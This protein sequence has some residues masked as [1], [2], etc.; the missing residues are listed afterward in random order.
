[1]LS[2][3]VFG[4]VE[5]SSKDEN[6]DSEGSSSS[7]KDKVQKEGTETDEKNEHSTT[8]ARKEDKRTVL[9]QFRNPVF[10][11]PLLY[12]ICYTSGPNFDD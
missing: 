10:I 5:Q 8:V 11:G 6:R 1:M 7:T 12:L 9:S 3:F 4:V 2:E